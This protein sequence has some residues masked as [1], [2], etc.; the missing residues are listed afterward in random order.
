M[1]KQLDSKYLITAFQNAI[2]NA[3][4]GEHT[5]KTD[6]EFQVLLLMMEDEHVLKHLKYLRAIHKLPQAISLPAPIMRIAVHFPESKKA[7]VKA[8]FSFDWSKLDS[9]WQNIFDKRATKKERR[10]KAA[11]SRARKRFRTQT[12]SITAYVE[13][14]RLLLSVLCGDELFRIRVNLRKLRTICLKEHQKLFEELLKNFETLQ[15]GSPWKYLL[16]YDC[17]L[18]QVTKELIVF[19][20]NEDEKLFLSTSTDSSIRDLAKIRWG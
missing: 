3:F 10:D 9:A 7:Q 14:S 1:R 2:K 13:C 16:D 18:L 8:L 20:A 12:F 5:D 4:V 19:R 15:K 11:K 6:W 17:E